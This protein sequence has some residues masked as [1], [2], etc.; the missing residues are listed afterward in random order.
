MTFKDNRSNQGRYE[1]NYSV[2]LFLFC[3]IKKR[4]KGEIADG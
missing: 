3:K 1:F 4:E 2:S